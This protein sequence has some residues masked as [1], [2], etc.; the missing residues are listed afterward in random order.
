MILSGC[1]KFRAKNIENKFAELNFHAFFLIRKI[2]K[3]MHEKCENAEM[4]FEFSRL[5]YGFVF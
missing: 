1:L 4:R 2:E 3:K 5:K